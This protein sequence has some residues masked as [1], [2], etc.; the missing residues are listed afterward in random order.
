MKGRKRKIERNQQ[1]IER[2]ILLSLENFTIKNRKL[3]NKT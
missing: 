1:E 2:N 3:T